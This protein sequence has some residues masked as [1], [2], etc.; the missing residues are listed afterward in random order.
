MSWFDLAQVGAYELDTKTSESFAL[1]KLIIRTGN[2]I[3]KSS[4][5]W[6][7]KR[8]EKEKRMKQLNHKT[9]EKINYGLNMQLC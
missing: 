5:V 4:I 6:I 2:E 7:E 3:A 1:I 9:W 8:E